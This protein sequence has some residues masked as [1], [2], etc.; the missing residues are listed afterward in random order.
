MRGHGSVKQLEPPDHGFT[1]ELV[2]PE[3]SLQLQISTHQD[4]MS[5]SLKASTYP[6]PVDPSQETSQPLRRVEKV[7]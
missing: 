2:C 4:W 5:E 3:L 6:L 7:S 1:G